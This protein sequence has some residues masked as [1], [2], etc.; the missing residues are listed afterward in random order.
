MADVYGEKCCSDGGHS[1]V[2]VNASEYFC[3]PC[4]HND[5]HSVAWGDADRHCNENPN[6]KYDF[7]TSKCKT[8][9]ATPDPTPSPTPTPPTCSGEGTIKPGEY[10][11]PMADV[12]GE[13]C[14]TDGGHSCVYV[15]ASEYFCLPCDHNDMHSVAWGDAD[16]HCNENPNCEYDFGTSKCKNKPAVSA[17]TPA[18]V[19]V[20]ATPAP[21]AAAETPAPVAAAACTGSGTVMPGEDCSPWMG[22]K[23]CSDG[24][25]ECVYVNGSEFL[26]LP[27]DH[28]DMHTVG[29]GDADG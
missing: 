26:C 10:C 22:A 12:Y 11:G 15:N 7:G 8:K 17:A 27:C 14:C 4:D 5:M 29:F 2:Y 3:L 16:R 25:H 1:C 18:P 9:P 21:V 24:G 28:D 23:C 13:K 6:C 19:A 20:A